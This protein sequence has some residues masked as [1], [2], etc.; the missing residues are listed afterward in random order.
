MVA[1]S[2]QMGRVG[3]TPLCLASISNVMFFFGRGN[4]NK[5][6]SG[7]ETNK[8]LRCRKRKELT[9]KNANTKL[10]GILAASRKRTTH[11]RNDENGKINW[12]CLLSFD[13]K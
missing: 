4:A 11:R 5:K 1:S 2:D 9:I 8:S 13:L 10:T 7:K 12:L 3:F 6:G